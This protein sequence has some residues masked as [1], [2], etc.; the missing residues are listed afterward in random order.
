[1]KNTPRDSD[2]FRGLRKKDILYGGCK[3]FAAFARRLH[4]GIT[5]HRS[6]SCSSLP[7]MPSTEEE[8]I[9][10]ICLC[11]PIT[12]G[13]SLNNNNVYS[14]HQ[15][16]CFFTSLFDRHRKLQAEIAEL[17]AEIAA[18]LQDDDVDD[19]YD[20]DDDDDDEDDDYDD[21]P[22][23]DP[24]SEKVIH[25][26]EQKSDQ[27]SND[28]TQITMRQVNFWLPHSPNGDKHLVFLTR[29]ASTALASFRITPRN[30]NDDDSYQSGEAN[31]GRTVDSGNEDG[32]LWV[33]E[34]GLDFIR[35]EMPDHVFVT[36]RPLVFV[37]GN[38]EDSNDPLFHCGAIIT[39]R[40]SDSDDDSDCHGVGDG[41]CSSEIRIAVCSMRKKRGEEEDTQ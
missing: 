20:D 31:N 23:K 24:L 26:M 25:A 18:G 28:S 13:L 14:L 35:E 40:G 4:Y 2:D 32:D 7:P 34:R 15:D 38:S 8:F 37:S 1:M 12:R 41:S 29:E 36:N 17:E 3:S 22:I 16:P 19:D 5:T 33:T 10:A 9:G 27:L 30:D 6:S 39:G 21:G 11:S